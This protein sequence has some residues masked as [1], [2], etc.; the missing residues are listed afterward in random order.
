MED[1][2]ELAYVSDATF[3]LEDYEM[4]PEG[5]R[6]EME[7]ILESSRKN[8][9]NNSLTGALLLTNGH[10]AQVLEGPQKALRERF[11][12]ISVDSRHTNI[13]TLRYG[14]VAERRF[15]NWEMAR[16]YAEEIPGCTDL[17]EVAGSPYDVDMSELAEQIIKSL[18]KSLEARASSG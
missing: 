10:F 8:N 3:A 5:I 14:P 18:A 4:D 12:I 1:L 17:I 7:A 9:E 13:V 16:C 2:Y 15:S 6:W 11:D